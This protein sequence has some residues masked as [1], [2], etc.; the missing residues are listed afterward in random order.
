MKDF[1]TCRRQ[2]RIHSDSAFRA[3][4][5]LSKQVKFIELICSGHNPDFGRYF[6][7]PQKR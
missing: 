7:R 2:V 6:L 3:L 1:N 4:A 5:E